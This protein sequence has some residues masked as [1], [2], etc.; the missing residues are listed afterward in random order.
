MSGITA[1]LV[2]ISP[3]GIRIGLWGLTSLIPPDSGEPADAIVVLGRGADLR[4]HRIAEVWK[5]WQ[6][7]RA[8]KIFASGMSDARQMVRSLEEM[9]VP[10]QRL[11]GEECSQS[12]QENA[13][14][15]SALLRSQGIKRIVLV[16]DSPHMLRSLLTFRSFGFHVIPHP[17]PQ[18]TQYPLPD[19]IG[20]LLR[21]YVGL[22]MYALTG[23]F[24]PH[25]T[26]VLNH[27]PTEVTQKI[28]DWVCRVGR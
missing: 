2:V 8:P 22:A 18:P 11:G 16:T 12:T 17:S 13:L 21:E 5:L 6:S 27:P 3:V 15:T 10:E 7:N 4:Q 1:M 9:G 14:F 23:Q 20:N 24:N 19:K 28:R 26:D 25:P